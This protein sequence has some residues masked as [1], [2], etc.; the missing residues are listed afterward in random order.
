MPKQDVPYLRTHEKSRSLVNDWTRRTDESIT[1]AAKSSH[2][3]PR[4]ALDSCCFG[5]PELS[6]REPVEQRAS[7]PLGCVLDMLLESTCVA[8]FAAETS[9]QSDRAATAASRVSPHWPALWKRVN[10]HF[11]TA[12]NGG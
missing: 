3:A 12:W 5:D 6:G 2:H 7:E 8:R 10:P 4:D 11:S 9:C 1:V